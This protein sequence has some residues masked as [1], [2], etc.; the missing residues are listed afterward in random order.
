VVL[1]FR[2]SHFLAPIRSGQLY[3]HPGVD[4][5]GNF[6]RPN[7]D[8]NAD[9]D[10]CSLHLPKPPTKNVQSPQTGVLLPLDE[11]LSLGISA[12]GH[13]V[14]HLREKLCGCYDYRMHHF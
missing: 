5:A 2:E 4:S 13:S 9:Y 10:Y 12:Y 11:H 3:S 1:R 6:P 8:H 7:G 14:Y